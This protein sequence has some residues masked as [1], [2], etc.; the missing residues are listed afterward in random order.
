MFDGPSIKAAREAK[1]MTQAELADAIGIAQQTVEKIESGKVQRTSYLPEIG[2]I[3]GL[4]DAL[5]PQRVLE[6]AAA[7]TGTL[8]PESAIRALEAGGFR[9]TL[10]D[11]R[12]GPKHDTIDDPVGYVREVLDRHDISASKLADKAGLAA[13]TLYRALND[14]NHR[15]I[16][17]GRTL[18]K[19]KQWDESQ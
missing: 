10:R 2:R 13:S 5:T 16:L 6:I 11:A 18:R 14:P 1:G 9:I 4:S 19:I 15:C 3:L 17:S 7:V 8:T 12:P